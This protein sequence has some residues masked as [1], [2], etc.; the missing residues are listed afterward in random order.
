MNKDYGLYIKAC[1]G[2]VDP[3]DFKA[4]IFHIP[5]SRSRLATYQNAVGPVY[6]EK[7]IHV[8]LGDENH[9]REAEKKLKQHFKDKINSSEAG[10]SEW[11]SGVELKEILDF[12]QELRTDYFIK[13]VD[14]PEEFV[15]LTMPKC[16]V[17]AEWY[18]SQK[19]G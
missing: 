2:V 3:K 9:V 16:E 1:P 14:V 19:N 17:M 8:W 6:E 7:F 13:L 18:E 10:L 11:I 12:I 4:G 15:P 5:A